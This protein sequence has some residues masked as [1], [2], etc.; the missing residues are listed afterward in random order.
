[1]N[2]ISRFF[3][4][5]TGKWRNTI[6]PVCGRFME[7]E[8]FLIEGGTVHIWYCKNP[9]HQYTAPRGL[10]EQIPKALKKKSGRP[11]TKTS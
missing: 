6:C 2:T 5:V 11:I 8:D 3:N 7:M 4:Y 1:M 9:G 10:F